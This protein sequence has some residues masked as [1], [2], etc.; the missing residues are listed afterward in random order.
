MVPTSAP[1]PVISDEMLALADELQDLEIP[2]DLVSRA[3]HCLAE[4]QRMGVWPAGCT[5]TQ[6]L[7]SLLRREMAPG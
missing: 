3:E 4:G 1:L 5:V 6:Y 2:A 7:V